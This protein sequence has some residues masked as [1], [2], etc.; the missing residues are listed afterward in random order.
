[1]AS[2]GL[3]QIFLFFLILLALTK[4]V[5]AYMARLFEGERTFLHP[6]VRPLERLVY[7]IGGGDEASEQHWTHYAGSVLGFRLAGILLTYL[8]PRIPGIQYRRK[9]RH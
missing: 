1:M 5:G 2:P 6:M 3:F 4:P 8:I 7:R 9:F